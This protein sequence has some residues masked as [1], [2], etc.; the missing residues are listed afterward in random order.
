MVMDAGAISAEIEA[1]CCRRVTTYV[2]LGRRNGS[3]IQLLNEEDRTRAYNT[4][5]P[6]RKI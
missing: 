6:A 5:C 3:V 2:S 4:T 1:V